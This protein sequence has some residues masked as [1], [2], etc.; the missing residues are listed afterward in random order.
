M[1]R[2]VLGTV[3]LGLAIGC[4][5]PALAGPPSIPVTV[6]GEP[7]NGI[8][9]QISYMVPQCIDLGEPGVAP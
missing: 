7:N 3:A 6:T 2:M 8:C 1:R 9:V 5:A 4:A